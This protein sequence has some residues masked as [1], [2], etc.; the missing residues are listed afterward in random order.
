MGNVFAASYLHVFHKVNTNN[1]FI[2]VNFKISVH[3]HNIP[4]NALQMMLIC[5][6]IAHAE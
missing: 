3:L 6:V 2:K 4:L 1:L 5:T